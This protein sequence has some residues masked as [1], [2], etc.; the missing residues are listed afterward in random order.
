MQRSVDAIVFDMDGTLLDSHEIVISAYRDTVADPAL[1]DA[2]VLAAFPAG[3]PAAVLARLLGRA[4]TAAE[5]RRY[6]A[7]LAD[8]A[9]RV[10]VYPGVT[11]LLAAAGQRAGLG[12][13][14]G[15]SRQAARI[16]LGFGGLLG[17]FRVIVGGDEVPAP[18][19]DPSGVL[20][21]CQALGVHASRVAYVGDS[22]LDLLAARRGGALAVAAAWSSPDLGGSAELAHLVAAT[23]SDVLSLLE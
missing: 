15:A 4:A 23:P 13:F 18:K 21:A 6:H 2:A 5:L 14:T 3:P 10:P 8:A 9:D 20:R 22:P 11:D 7:L 12:V 1:S 16:L 19:P 17:Y